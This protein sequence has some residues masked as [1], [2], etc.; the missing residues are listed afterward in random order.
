VEGLSSDGLIGVGITPDVHGFYVEVDLSSPNAVEL[1]APG[2]ARPAAVARSSSGALRIVGRCE[3]I[4]GPRACIWT[5]TAQPWFDFAP[6]PNVPTW[7]VTEGLDLQ[8]INLQEARDISAAGDV[9]VGCGSENGVETG[10]R[11]DV[12]PLGP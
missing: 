12:A 7:T 10:W 11:L 6:N 2:Q 9:I 3:E 4:V 5:D 8:G 1:P